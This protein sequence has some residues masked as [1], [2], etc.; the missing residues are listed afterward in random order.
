MLVYGTLAGEPLTVDSRTLMV[1]SKRVVGFWLSNW[2]RHQ[3]PLTMLRLFKQITLLLRAG[4]L[5]SEVSARFPLS[6]IRAAVKQAEQPG[7]QGKV[8]LQIA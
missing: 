4:I 8:L 7:R 1:G 3:N 2:V 6:D 5:T